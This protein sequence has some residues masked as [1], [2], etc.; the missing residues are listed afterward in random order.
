MQPSPQ[1]IV[2]RFQHLKNKPWTFPGGLVVRTLCFHC[3]D[4]G[5]IPGLGTKILQAILHSKNKNKTKQNKKTIL[6]SLAFT[7]LQS[8]P[9]LQP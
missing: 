3:Q 7:F 8:T 2:E 1:S 5:S 6:Y 4:V 9:N